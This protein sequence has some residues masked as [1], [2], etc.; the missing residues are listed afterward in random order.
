MVTSLTLKMNTIFH[1]AL[2]SSPYNK[3]TG[4]I[5]GLRVSTNHKLYCPHRVDFLLR[6]PPKYLTSE[7]DSFSYFLCGQLTDAVP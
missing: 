7:I 6:K 3:Q 2:R 1:R 5:K 4:S